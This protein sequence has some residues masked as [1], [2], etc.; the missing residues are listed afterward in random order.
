MLGKKIVLHFK[1]ALNYKLII[2]EATWMF[3]YSFSIPNS[4]ILH[5]WSKAVKRMGKWNYSISVIQAWMG[6]WKRNIIMDVTA[7]NLKRLMHSL[8]IHFEPRK[9]TVLESNYKQIQFRTIQRFF[10]FH[11]Q[12][13]ISLPSQMNYFSVCKS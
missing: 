8:K 5:I 13:C 6:A 10:I 12:F 3:R 11:K 1:A 7:C 2:W 9:K 4:A